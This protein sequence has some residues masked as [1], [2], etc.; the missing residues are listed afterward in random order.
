MGASG[1]ASRS[2][3]GPG[4]RALSACVL[5]AAWLATVAS[6][7]ALAGCGGDSAEPSPATGG[8][9]TVQS[10]RGA[11]ALEALL[12]GSI[13]GARLTKASATGAAV[14]GGDAFSRALTS[15]LR[16]VERRPSD[17][18]FA[19]ARTA[20]GVVE[21]GVFEL[22][23]VA[24][25]RLLRAIVA[26]SRPNARGLTT[27]PVAIAGKAATK[28]TY[29]GGAVLYLRASGR[30]VFYVGTQSERLAAEAF[31]ELP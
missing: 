8:A 30:H 28:L 7:I 2:G 26:A 24:G 27:S 20:S 12:P 6:G 4:D 23:G 9:T 10:S 22:P 13:A 25:P 21:V 17:L 19:N 31:G 16:S 29:P 5:A 11:S 1:H 18:R 15:F 3:E 14:F